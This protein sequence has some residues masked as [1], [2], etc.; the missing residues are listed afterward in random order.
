[1]EVMVNLTSGRFSVWVDHVLVGDNIPVAL[2]PGPLNQPNTSISGIRMLPASNGGVGTM[3]VDN[4]Y[5]TTALP[6]YDN[7]ESE[8]VGTAP[9]HWTVLT[10]GAQTAVTVVPDTTPSGGTKSVSLVDGNASGYC[11]VQYQAKQPIQVFY[12]RGNYRFG[13]TN[14]VHY[15]LSGNGNASSLYFIIANSNGTWSYYD[16]AKYVRFLGDTKGYVAN[17]WYQV[18]V[19]AD[20]TTTTHKFSVWVDGVLVGNNIDLPGYDP[21]ILV[22][23]SSSISGIRLLPTSSLGTGAMWV[24]NIFF[25]NKSGI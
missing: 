3:W 5:L 16:G 20:L 10:S 21:K 13:E 14:T 8:N 2:G 15:V 22:K 11:Q 1:M 12:Y 6:F 19:M 25:E 7:F 17:R 18:E 23:P 4:V 24:D 9:S